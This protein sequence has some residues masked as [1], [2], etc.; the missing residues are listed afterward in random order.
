M[1]KIAFGQPGFH[2][3]V[4]WSTREKIRR[5]LRKTIKRL[6]RA[7]EAHDKRL[8]GGR[9]DECTLTSGQIGGLKAALRMLGGRPEW[10]EELDELGGTI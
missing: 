4:E 7:M 8:G 2:L 3:W 1:R 5:T 10:G 9:C 6:E